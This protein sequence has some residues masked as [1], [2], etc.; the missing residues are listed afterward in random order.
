[1]AII[2]ILTAMFIS[3]KKDI[4]VKSVELNQNTATLAPGEVLKL[5]ATVKPSD[6]TNNEVS[7]TSS[8]KS[9]ATVSSSGVVTAVA[10]GTSV[11]TVITDDGNKMDDCII[12]V[13]PEGGGGGGGENEQAL[14]SS[15]VDVWNEETISFTYN[16]QNKLTSVNWDNWRNWSITYPSNNSIR[17][18]MEEE[19]IDYM[20]TLNNDGYIVKCCVDGECW[21]YEYE[22]GYLKRELHDN[23]DYIINYIWENGNL[24][25]KQEN[26]YSTTYSYG[27]T[28]YK[29]TNIAPYSLPPSSFLEEGDMYINFILP[30]AYFGKRSKNLI[31]SKTTNVPYN[32][33]A[34]YRYQTNSD[35]YVTKVYTDWGWGEELRFEIRY[36]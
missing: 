29:E 21:N 12:T 15:I 13:T 3:C 28:P 36:K 31:T 22:N 23:G 14:V 2:G 18:I 30:K 16:T 4:P 33:N 27:T 17:V 8:N 19:G 6:A 9:V 5:K 25:S 7:W 35:G 10:V 1:M 20:L 32:D 34:T 24:K 11:I 26:G